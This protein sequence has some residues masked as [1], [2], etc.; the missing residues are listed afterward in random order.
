MAT[1]IYSDAAYNDDDRDDKAEPQALVP[2]T[3]LGHWRKR[4]KQ[5]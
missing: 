3:Y 5:S 2:E 1:R 4:A